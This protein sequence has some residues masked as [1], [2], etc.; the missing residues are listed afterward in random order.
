MSTLD[1]MGN[2]LPLS[3]KANEIGNRAGVAEQGL[4]S[5]PAVLIAGLS[6][7]PTIREQ[8]SLEKGR[9]PTG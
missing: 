9:V 3:T 6:G 4:K 7:F 2:L 1:V 5:A 8:V